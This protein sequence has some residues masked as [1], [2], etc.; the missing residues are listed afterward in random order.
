MDI[1]TRITSFLTLLKWYYSIRADCKSSEY[2]DMSGFKGRHYSPRRCWRCDRIPK[3][4]QQKRQTCG[5]AGIFG[6][7]WN[8]AGLQVNPGY[9][10]PRFLQY[11][12]A[13]G[14]VQQIP[15]EDISIA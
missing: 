3:D 8:C 12:F 9:V 13:A 4:P 15:E 14:G 6:Q 11:L 10:R 1:I 2:R 5:Y 7:R